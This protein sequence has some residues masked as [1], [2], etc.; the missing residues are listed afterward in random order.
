M[1]GIAIVGEVPHKTSQ[2]VTVDTR[3]QVAVLELSLKFGKEVSKETHMVLFY[4][5][6]YVDK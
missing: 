4:G 1:N 3:H 5:L 6:F 2:D